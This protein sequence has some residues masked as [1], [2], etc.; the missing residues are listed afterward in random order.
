MTHQ[1]L[2]TLLL[3][4]RWRSSSSTS[5]GFNHRTLSWTSSWN[6]SSQSTSQP[7]VTSMPS[8]RYYMYMQSWLY[9]CMH[10]TVWT[11]QRCFNLNSSQLCQSVHQ[12]LT[13]V[14]TCTY[15]RM[16]Q[17]SDACPHKVTHRP[18]SWYTCVRSTQ[19]ATDTVH[20][21]AFVHVSDYVLSYTYVRVSVIHVCRYW[22]CTINN[23]YTVVSSYKPF[24]DRLYVRRW[25]V[26]MVNQKNSALWFWMSHQLSSL[27]P[28][29]WTYIWEQSQRRPM[30]NLLWVTLCNVFLCWSIF[31]VHKC[32]RT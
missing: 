29:C 11:Q 19:R 4:L 32:V 1:S 31:C 21:H 14:C 7:L 26:Q 20:V 12:L 25:A 27:T 17:R 13:Y 2:T 9:A 28:Q 5:P 24:N 10:Y 15:I 3:A 22:S 18:Q 8:W 30:S 23:I 16:Y 6:L